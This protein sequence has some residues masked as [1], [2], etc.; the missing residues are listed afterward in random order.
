MPSP[1]AARRGGSRPDESP[2]VLKDVS[3]QPGRGRR[4]YRCTGHRSVVGVEPSPPP[5]PRQSADSPR[6]RP[7]GGPS[8]SSRW[9]RNS[10]KAGKRSRP[11]R[12]REQR[13]ERQA[14][15]VISTQRNDGG[16]R[17]APEPALLEVPTDDA[18]SADSPATAG[19]ASRSDAVLVVSRH[20]FVKFVSE[21]ARALV[22]AYVAPITGDW[23]PPSRVAWLAQSGRGMPFVAE[24]DGRR[25]L[26]RPLPT[27]DPGE[28][29]L[30]V[31]EQRQP[32][33][34]PLRRHGLT[35]REHEVL[36][37]V[38]EGKTNPEIGIILGR[39]ARTVQIHLNRVYRK[40]GV[41]TRTAAAAPA[42][43]ASL[44]R[45]PAL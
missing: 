35:P 39:S 7:R 42:L 45:D 11:G 25:L 27:S 34:Q 26:M 29:V 20:G 23:L 10:W 6:S 18:W 15:P 5:Q 36:W 43:R 22:A 4:V 16:G 30:L 3:S 9:S 17:V 1:D 14:M 21:H 13:R 41:E 44:V 40:L 38:T 33:H 8:E 2:S 12:S 28:I 24:Q 37:W 19:D 31:Q 32:L